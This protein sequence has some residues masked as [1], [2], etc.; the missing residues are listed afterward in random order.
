MTKKAFKVPKLELG[1]IGQSI[2]VGVGA[3]KRLI[4]GGASAALAPHYVTNKETKELELVSPGGNIGRVLRG[5][6]VGR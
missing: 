4:G 5:F 2:G 1:A 6:G 3:P